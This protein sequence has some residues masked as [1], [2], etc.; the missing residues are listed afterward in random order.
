MFLHS[1]HET[2]GTL[3]AL[4]FLGHVVSLLPEKDAGVFI[5]EK[6]GT[7][8]IAIWV[9]TSAGKPEDGSSIPRI[10]RVE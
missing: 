6:V 1:E 3:R 4:H 2:F 10:L 5:N 7:S 8:K 9:K